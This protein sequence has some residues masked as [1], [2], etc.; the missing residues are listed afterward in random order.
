M[1]GK[2]T[3]GRKAGIPNKVTNELREQVNAFLKKNWSKVQQDFDKLKPVDKLLFM[4]KLMKYSI[5]ALSS[6]SGSINFDRLPDDQLDELIEKWK[7]IN[8]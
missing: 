3:G 4:E 2:K 1:E 8:K 6:I 5:P 7:N